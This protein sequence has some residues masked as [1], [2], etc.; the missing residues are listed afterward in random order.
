M[1]DRDVLRGSGNMTP[2]KVCATLSKDVSQEGQR[3]W[4]GSGAQ[5]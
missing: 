2:D 1:F 5:I 4:E 3:S